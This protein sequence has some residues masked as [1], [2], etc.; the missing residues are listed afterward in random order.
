MKAF[1]CLQGLEGMETHLMSKVPREAP[2]TANGPRWKECP[3]IREG[4]YPMKACWENISR[5]P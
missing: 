2:G 1:T 5:K 4:R 3:L